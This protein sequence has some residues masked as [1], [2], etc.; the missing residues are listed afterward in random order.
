[1]HPRPEGIIFRITPYL[2]FSHDKYE[3]EWF[4][5]PTSFKQEIR[6]KSEKL[7]RKDSLEKVCLIVCQIKPQCQPYHK[8]KPRGLIFASLHTASGGIPPAAC[9]GNMLW[10]ER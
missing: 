8:T 10:M 5:W 4:V 6:S 7:S 2:P 9:C 1:M 3:E